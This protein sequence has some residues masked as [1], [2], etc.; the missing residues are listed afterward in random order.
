MTEELNKLRELQ[1]L[2]SVCPEINMANYGEDE[3]KHLNDWAIE[4]SNLAEALTTPQ[5]P[6]AIALNDGARQGIKWLVRDLPDQTPL[7]ASPPQG[8]TP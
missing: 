4:M 5:Q 3:V 8:A 2:A 6:V 1:T 7:Y